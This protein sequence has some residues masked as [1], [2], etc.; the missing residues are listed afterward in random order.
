[1]WVGKGQEGDFPSK[2]LLLLAWLISLKTSTPDLK[3]I[4]FLICKLLYY[5]TLTVSKKTTSIPSADSQCED[6]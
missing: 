5:S 3:S 6:I 1:M 4:K 2:L